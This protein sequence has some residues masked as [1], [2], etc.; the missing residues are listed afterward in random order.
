MDPRHK[1]LLTTNRVFLV[2]NLDMPQLID[3]MI[4]TELLS[5]NDGELLQVINYLCHCL[6]SKGIVSCCVCV[7][8]RRIV[9]AAKVMHCVQCCL[10]LR[11]LLIW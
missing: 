2:N 8:V 6:A 10:V 1:R 9:S 7:C 4:G 5:D 11:L 3:H